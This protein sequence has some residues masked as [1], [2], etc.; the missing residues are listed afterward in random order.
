MLSWTSVKQGK[1]GWGLA[2]V[3][4]RTLSL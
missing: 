4:L 3:I 2:N 1:L